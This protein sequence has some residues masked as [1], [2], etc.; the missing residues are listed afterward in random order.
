MEAL[1]SQPLAW[2]SGRYNGPFCPQVATER[3]KTT[4]RLKRMK[5]PLAF[6]DIKAAQYTQIRLTLCRKAYALD[7]LLAASPAF[8]DRSWLRWVTVW[9]VISP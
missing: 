7:A 8:M 6:K 3:T 1:C 2:G 5:S 9:E 4:S